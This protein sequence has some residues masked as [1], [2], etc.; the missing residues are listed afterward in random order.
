ML[1]DSSVLDLIFWLRF[2][3]TNW[4]ALSVEKTSKYNT[5]NLSSHLLHCDVTSMYGA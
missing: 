4:K 2:S 5:S 3:L 1:V